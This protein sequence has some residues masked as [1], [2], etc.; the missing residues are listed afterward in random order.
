MNNKG[1]VEIGSFILLFVGIIV[2]IVLFIAASQQLTTVVDLSVVTNST[3]TFPTNTTALA[4]N[5]QA[6]SNFVALNATSAVLVPTTN[7]TIT[8][9]V[10]SN[11]G[12]L[13]ATIIGLGANPHGGKSV[14]V[15]YTYEPLGYA[16]ESASRTIA[17]LIVILS[18]LAIAAW[19]IS[20]V[21]EDGVDAF[22]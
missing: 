5:G 1:E 21:Y 20:K 12:T 4:L 14:N 13:Q 22:R 7:Y 17:E 11:T 8:N 19:V 2:A 9:Y 16:K 3:I 15:S 18:A 6:V 10:I